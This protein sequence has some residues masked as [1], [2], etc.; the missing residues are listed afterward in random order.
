MRPIAQD[1][2]EQLGHDANN[3]NQWMNLSTVM[4]GLGQRE[5]GFSTQDQALSLIQRVFYRPATQSPTRFRLLM[6]M[7]PGDIAANTPLDCLLENTDI[8]LIYYYTH[9]DAPLP[10]PV[11]EH[12]A[13][14]VALGYAE[15]HEALLIRLEDALATWP[16]PVINA[17]R[18][19]PH[20][21]RS[22][23]SALLQNIPGLLMPPT[24]PVDRHQLA[25]LAQNDST[26]SS[27]YSGWNFPIIVRPV[28]SHAGR[29]LEKIDQPEALNRYLGQVTATD[30]FISPFVDYRGAD[31]LFRKF[32]IALIDGAP[33]ICHMAISN[34]WMIHYLNA[35]MY[36]DAA[37]RAEEAAFMADFDAFAARHRAALAEVHARCG[38]DYVCFDGAETPDGQLLIFEIDHVMV[39][40]A[41]DPID[42]FPYKPP[43]IQRAQTAFEQ[44]L[45]RRIL[46]ATSAAQG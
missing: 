37:K 39:V 40:H 6:L 41:M 29:D 9:P 4:F 22:T 20:T 11:P 35:G 17:P 43:L 42:R 14:L 36:E 15:A 33:F 38:L 16:R 7:V 23:A 2:L 27:Q 10:H 19:I 44:M 45:G 46:A 12:D 8:E 13:V 1:M 18:F 31:G 24:Q 30:F 28:D 32:R 34:H 3:A 26:L 5:M 25:A 21:D